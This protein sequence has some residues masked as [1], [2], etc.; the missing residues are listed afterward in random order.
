MESQIHTK[1]RNIKLI[2]IQNTS[3]LKFYE[4]QIKTLEATGK[5]LSIN[6]SKIKNYWINIYT[7]EKSIAKITSKIKQ[8]TALI[9]QNRGY[10][11]FFVRI[12]NSLQ[13]KH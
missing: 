13:Q 1:I 6:K 4:T 5:L 3:D 11:H 12:K 7:I 10:L 9:E 2:L 8:V